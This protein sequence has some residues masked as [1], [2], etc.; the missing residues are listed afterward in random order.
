MPFK[1][2]FMEVLKVRLCPVLVGITLHF[3]LDSLINTGTVTGSVGGYKKR[4]LCL[5][6]TIMAL[7]TTLSEDDLLCDSPL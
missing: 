6:A 5:H 3:Y 1:V 7:L 4:L 2:E